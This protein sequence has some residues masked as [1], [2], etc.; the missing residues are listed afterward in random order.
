MTAAGCP[1][2]WP[3]CDAGHT[4]DGARQNSGGSMNS[5]TS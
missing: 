1:E 3:E 4:A 5:R 2:I